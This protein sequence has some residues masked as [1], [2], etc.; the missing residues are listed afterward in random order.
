MRLVLALSLAHVLALAALPAAAACTV[1]RIV[2]GDTL[3][4]D[5]GAGDV[6]VRLLGYDTP[7]IF[8]PKCAAEARRGAE[9]T[10]LL[11]A[12][13]ARGPV[14]GFYPQGL[15]RYG[16]TLARVAIAG[17]DVTDFMLATP[18]ALPYQGHAHPDWCGTS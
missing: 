16:R 10:D 12:L 4:L 7:E 18:L 17:Q 11:A 15:D 2:D 3:H 8:H 6:K 5:C 1:T 14:T 13:V 9:A